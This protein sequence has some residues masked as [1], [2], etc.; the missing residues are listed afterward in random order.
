[1]KQ[2]AL[3][4]RQMNSLMNVGRALDEAIVEFRG[5]TPAEIAT[6]AHAAY[7]SM[8]SLQVASP[9]PAPVKAP[10]RRKRRAKK[11]AKAK[12]ATTVAVKSDKAT[13]IMS[14]LKKAKEPMPASAIAEKLGTSGQGLGPVLNKLHTDGEITKKTVDGSY[15]WGPKGM[16]KLNGKAVHA[17]N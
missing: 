16:S 5:K 6:A 9:G 1:M 3:S 11:A 14:V 13:D 12:P 10:V 2:I 17:P 8:L 4:E 7:S 15:V